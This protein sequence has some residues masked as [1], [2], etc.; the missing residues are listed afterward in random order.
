MYRE[1][2][3]ISQMTNTRHT[4]CAFRCIDFSNHSTLLKN[5]YDSIFLGCTIPLE[6]FPQLIAKNNFLLQQPQ[7]PF[8]PFR[9]TLY[10]PLE[11]LDGYETSDP[12]TFE[13]HSRDGL[14][15]SYFTANDIWKFLA[16]FNES[17]I[18]LSMMVSMIY[19]PRKIVNQKPLVLWE[20]TLL[21]EPMKHSSRL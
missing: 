7:L 17:M 21:I 19:F 6:N 13:T 11:L 14:I 15:Y 18:L 1:F 20:D 8:S 5:V 9:A 10:T 12:N 3:N 2:T 4:A 16:S